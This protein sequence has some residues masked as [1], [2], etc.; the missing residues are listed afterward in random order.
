MN[1]GHRVLLANESERAQIMP[2]RLGSVW[3]LYGVPLKLNKSGFTQIT[4]GVVVA[5]SEENR[6]THTHT[7]ESKNEYEMYK[8]QLKLMQL[9]CIGDNNNLTS[10][11]IVRNFHNIVGR[12]RWMWHAVYASRAR[13]IEPV[14]L[15]PGAHAAG[16]K[17]TRRDQWRNSNN[18]DY[19]DFAFAHRKKHLACKQPDFIG[20]FSYM[21]QS[22]TERRS[23]FDSS[24]STRNHSTLCSVCGGLFQVSFENWN[25]SKTAKEKHKIQSDS[26]FQIGF[27]ELGAIGNHVEITFPCDALVLLRVRR[28]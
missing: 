15:A 7:L 3:V 9:P 18:N 11:K 12:T 10:I 22:I 24:C 5:G 25:F 13:L 2:F 6:A 21:D 16:R 23:I 14:L 27:S 19:Y 8:S 17:G 26:V 20:E 4:F 28:R 1:G